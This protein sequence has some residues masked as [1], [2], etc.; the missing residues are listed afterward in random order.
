VR[1]AECG[2]FYSKQMLR[3]VERGSVEGK[4]HLREF[5]REMDLPMRRHNV[6]VSRAGALSV[7]ELSDCFWVSPSI[8]ILPQCG[9]RSHRPKMGNDSMSNHRPAWYVVKEQMSVWFN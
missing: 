3:K 6:I 1:L 8:F 4:L 9:R 2:K 7:S 5:I